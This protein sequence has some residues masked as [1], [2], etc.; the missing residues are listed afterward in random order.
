MEISCRAIVV[1]MSMSLMFGFGFGFGFTGME[2][3]FVDRKKR[4]QNKVTS[5][6]FWGITIEVLNGRDEVAMMEEVGCY[7]ASDWVL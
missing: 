3:R 4:G 5:M 7:E 6:K 2:F 1:G